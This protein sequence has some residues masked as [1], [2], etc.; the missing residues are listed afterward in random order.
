M[1]KSIYTFQCHHT[2]VAEPQTGLHSTPGECRCG[3]F[4]GRKIVKFLCPGCMLFNRAAVNPPQLTWLIEQQKNTAEIILTGSFSDNNKKITPGAVDHK[5][6]NSSGPLSPPEPVD[7][8]FRPTSYAA[9]VRG[10]PGTQQSTIQ[11][12]TGTE[13]QQIQQKNYRQQYGRIYSGEPG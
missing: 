8:N 13:D 4:D 7:Q 3:R 9:A 11:K 6:G 2:S 12:G 5:S 1:C 10:K